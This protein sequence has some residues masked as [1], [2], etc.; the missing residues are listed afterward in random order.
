MDS[1]TLSLTSFVDGVG[2]LTPPPGRF[3]PE[4]T[5]YQLYR[6]GGPQ[7]RCARLWK[8]LLSRS[9]DPHNAKPVA[10]IYTD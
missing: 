9:F 6:L 2:W 5:W 1:F 8:I 3:A 7:G 10:S 4:M